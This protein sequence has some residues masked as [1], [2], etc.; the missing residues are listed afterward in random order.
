MGVS[1]T[2]W[3]PKLRLWI[4]GHLTAKTSRNCLTA[5]HRLLPLT[6]RYD[7]LDC[8]RKRL[9]LGSKSWFWNTFFFPFSIAISNGFLHWKWVSLLVWYKQLRLPILV[10][11]FGH[12]WAIVYQE[13]YDITM[14]F[15]SI[16]LWLDYRFPIW[17]CNL[18]ITI[19][20]YYTV[21][22]QMKYL[23]KK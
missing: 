13:L 3:T 11:L 16:H 22:G 15:P 17:C 10:V 7:C 23:K 18:Y 21:L 6:A 8:L 19:L 14:S 20:I 4:F 2:W 9:R 1:R 5:S 12:I